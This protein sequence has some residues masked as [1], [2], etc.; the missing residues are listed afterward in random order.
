MGSAK[1]TLLVDRSTPGHWRI[2]LD[3]PPVNVIDD[4]MYDAFYDL[5]GEIE[6]DAAVKVVTFESANPD[7]FIAHYGTAGPP[8]RFGVPPW[9]DAATRLA[10]SGALSIA[11]I[12]G[13]V[14]GGGS[15]FA[16]ACDIRFAS[17]EKAIF[18]QPEVGTG[19][20]PGGGALQRLP[21]LVGRSRALEII[22]GANDFDADTAERYG[23]INRALP[24]AEL[25]AFVADFVRR[26]LS[27]DQQALQAAKSIVNQA[28]L[29]DPVALKATQDIFFQT[30]SWNGAKDRFPKL[31]ARGIGQAGDFEL[32]LGRHIGNL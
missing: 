5:V 9:I 18:G 21:T 20:I 17:R 6:A 23:W 1:Q 24:D 30:F 12:R 27:F 10:K 32:N 15:E 16:L 28:G 7:F 4:V 31:R 19:L 11:V 2:T 14:R 26:V 13:R 8:S 29:P 22:M 3:N 25:D